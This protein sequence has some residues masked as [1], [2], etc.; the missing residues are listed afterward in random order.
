MQAGIISPTYVHTKNQ[1]ADIFNKIV[2]V[3][4]HTFLLS[5]L[6]ILNL[7]SPPNLRGSVENT[8]NAATSVVEEEAQG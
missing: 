8:G 5:K 2:F 6:G 4:Q 3:A 7:F 1:L